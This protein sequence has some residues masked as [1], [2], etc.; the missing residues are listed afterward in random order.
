MKISE[1]QVLRSN[2]G[3]Y[4]G[5]TYFDEETGCWFPYDRL[6]EGYYST[7]QEA[8]IALLSYLN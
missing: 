3:Y 4:I 2:A 7:R 8:D 6:S 5:R 1:I